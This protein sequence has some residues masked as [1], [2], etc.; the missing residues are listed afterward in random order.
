MI[1]FVLFLVWFIYLGKPNGHIVHCKLQTLPNKLVYACQN[2]A[3]FDE[4]M[5]LKLIVEILAPY[6]A[7]APEG[8]VPI[9]FL[10]SFLVHM[11]VT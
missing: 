11:K 8:V 5:M 10:D 2:K 1:L 6:V 9:L 7:A 3:W 4:P